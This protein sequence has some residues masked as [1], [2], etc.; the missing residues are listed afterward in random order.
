[1][2]SVMPRR[3]V[4]VLTA[5]AFACGGDDDAHEG[6]HQF[7]PVDCTAETRADAFSQG[8]AKTGPGGLTFELTS[9]DPATPVKGDNSWQVLITDG[10]SSVRDTPK[11][12]L[13]LDVT[14]W[15]PD[16]GHG[17]QVAPGV[18]DAGDGTYMIDMIN[19]RMP[20]YWEVT[21]A[22][23]DGNETSDQ[24]TFNLCVSG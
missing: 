19:L 23:D 12:G 24:V 18:T 5:L 2:L 17:T 14:P 1:M 13:T 6:G 15:M 9:A 10:D 8:L 22:A 7:E 16:H 4:L 3:L 21:V 11:P 20:G